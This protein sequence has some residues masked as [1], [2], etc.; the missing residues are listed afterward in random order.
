MKSNAKFVKKM[1]NI[2][3]Q[4]KLLALLDISISETRWIQILLQN[5]IWICMSYFQNIHLKL[6]SI[7]GKF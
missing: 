2:K 7:S 6:F 3:H 1:K 4:E 5:S